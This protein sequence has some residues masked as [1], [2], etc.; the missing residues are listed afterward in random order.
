MGRTEQEYHHRN[1]EQSSSETAISDI[2]DPLLQQFLSDFSQDPFFQEDQAVTNLSA[3]R[4]IIGYLNKYISDHPELG[5]H[6]PHS[7]TNDALIRNTLDGFMLPFIPVKSVSR[8]S[9]SVRGLTQEGVLSYAALFWSKMLIE[10]DEKIDN[11]H[12][13]GVILQK[14]VDLLG[15]S[16]LAENIAITT[17]E[18]ALFEKY[19][20]NASLSSVGSYPEKPVF[21]RSRQS[22]NTEVVTI[23]LEQSNEDNSVIPNVEK[24][25]VIGLEA[26]NMERLLIA[27]KLYN[28]ND[29]EV[30]GAVIT[31]EL[32]SVV[33]FVHAYVQQNFDTYNPFPT[34]FDY[35]DILEKLRVCGLLINDIKGRGYMVDNLADLYKGFA[36]QAAEEGMRIIQS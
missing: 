18:R 19:F 25:E 16:R 32:V 34:E 27:P 35:D 22:A 21:D 14:A 5:L 4:K 36:K 6:S 15:E 7:N 8:T 2:S 20:R 29:M 13:N 26:W 3:G 1:V 24:K 9:R 12:V 23:E 28:K 17:S 10:N 31:R 30:L 11:N 33:E